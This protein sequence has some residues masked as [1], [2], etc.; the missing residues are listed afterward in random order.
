MVI[1]KQGDRSEETDD[2]STVAY[3]FQTTSNPSASFI[4]ILASVIS[5]TIVALLILAIFVLVLIACKR[6]LKTTPVR[7]EGSVGRE[8]QGV[9]RKEAKAVPNPNYMDIDA[10][11]HWKSVT[12]NCMSQPKEIGELY[13]LGNY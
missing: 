9:K 12:G 3:T 2:G 7:K 13:R 8:D 6:H 5:G 10:S 11:T 1:I 4:I